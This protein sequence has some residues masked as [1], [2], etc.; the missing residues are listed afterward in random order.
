MR[1]SQRQNPT[2]R[3]AF[4]RIA[5]GL[6]WRTRAALARVRDVE[7]AFKKVFWRVVGFRDSERKLMGD[8]QTYWN[9]P[10][11]LS[12]QQNSHWRGAGIFVDDARWLALGRQHLHLYEQ[13]ARAIDHLRPPKRIVEWGCGGGMNAVHFAALAD[14]FYGVDI[15]SASLDEC[16]KQM[17]IA[18]LH[19]FSPVLI[20]V[21]NP[22][23][24]L[25]QIPASCDLAIST[26]VFEL[27]P[28]PE[29][30]YRILKIVY[31]LLAPS[32]IAIVQIKYSEGDWKTRSQRW[33]Y[34]RNLAWNATYRIEEFWQAAE[35]CGFMPKMVTLVPKQPL[36]NDRNYAYLLLQK[37]NTEIQTERQCQ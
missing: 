17:N 20:D 35:R 13:F 9:N 12:L 29:Y 8:S 27:L 16:A 15:S 10:P 5:E 34:V 3:R 31:A 24:A 6:G 30:G 26:Y 2:A 18:G 25:R 37:P 1:Q 19:N 21:A 22:E 11:D 28:T 4:L 14:D 33:S 23:A 36:V 32:G 7:N